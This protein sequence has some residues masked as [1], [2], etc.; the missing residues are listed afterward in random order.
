VE[1][2]T[3]PVAV[4]LFLATCYQEA[5]GHLTDLPADLLYARMLGWLPRA[6]RRPQ[7]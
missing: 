3:Q 5:A 7:E 4:A 2:G 6:A 1:Y